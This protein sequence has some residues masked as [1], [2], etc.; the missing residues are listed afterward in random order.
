MITRRVLL[1]TMTAAI[2]TTGL[3][4]VASTDWVEFQPWQ[5]QIDSAFEFFDACEFTYQERCG[6]LYV[7]PL[8]DQPASAQTAN[9]AIRQVLSRLIKTSPY[10]Q[11]R[12]DHILT[13]ARNLE[14]R[15]GHDPA[16]HREYLETKFA[17]HRELTM[18]QLMTNGERHD[19]HLASRHTNRYI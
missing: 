18:R 1:S 3:P 8:H 6:A 2:A 4:A 11:E 17:G 15:H 14:V 12:I 9:H 5:A 7:R 16:K 19:L 13:V 10:K